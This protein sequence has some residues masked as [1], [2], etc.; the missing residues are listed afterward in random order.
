[1]DIAEVARRAGQPAST[2]R[3][4]EERGLIASIG[5][6]GLRRTFEPTVLKQLA[7]I[8]LA[9]N[10]GFSLGEI[11]K[12]IGPDGLGREQ[13]AAKAQELDA[14]IKKLRT[15]R[16]ELKRAAAC[17]EASHFACP[18]FQARLVS[19]ADHKANHSV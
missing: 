18:K 10:A 7:L 15:M 4:Y 14:T 3:Y 6:N 5:R 19:R 1:M 12:L 9:R 16:D 2:L 13:L 8:A 17:P 11:A